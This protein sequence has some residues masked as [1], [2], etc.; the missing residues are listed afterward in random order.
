ARASKFHEPSVSPSCVPPRLNVSAALAEGRVTVSPAPDSRDAS[1]SS[2]ISMLGAP[3]AALFHLQVSGARSGAHHG[4]LL[5]YSQGDGA[6]FVPSTPF[7]Q[8]ERVTVRALL[9]QGAR[10]VPFAWS[11]T[12][13]VQDHG[14]HAGG[15]PRPAPQKAAYQRFRSRPDLQPPTVT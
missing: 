11:F 7:I 1:V 2:Q 10:S 15:S 8:G 12:T 4:R 6:S 9:G 3:A 5:P 14:G 13:A